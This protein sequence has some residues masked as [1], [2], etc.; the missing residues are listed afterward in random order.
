[1]RYVECSYRKRATPILARPHD[2]HSGD[3]NGTAK[4]LT[5][6]HLV[7]RRLRNWHGRNVWDIRCEEAWRTVYWAS[8]DSRVC[9]K[10]SLHPKENRFL[11]SPNLFTTQAWARWRQSFQ[12]DNCDRAGLAELRKA[13]MRLRMAETQPTSPRN[14]YSCGQEKSNGAGDVEHALNVTAPR[15][16]AHSARH[17]TASEEL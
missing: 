10:H 17:R 5:S 6:T 13:V 11:G 4:R 12:R 7:G 1:M 2:L 16:S 3:N 8:E 9:T 14:I 15:E